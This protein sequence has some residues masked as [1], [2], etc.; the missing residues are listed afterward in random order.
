MRFLSL[1]LSGIT[2]LECFNDLPTL[3]PFTTFK[4]AVPKW[5]EGKKKGTRWTRR[6]CRGE[7]TP[8]EDGGVRARREAWTPR[9]PHGL[10]RNQPHHRLLWG[11]QPSECETMSFC[12]LSHPVCASLLRQPWETTS[13]IFIFNLVCVTGLIKILDHDPL[14]SLSWECSA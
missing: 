8:G 4:P 11:V 5:R 2:L 3:L 14:S 1:S 9:L 10:R 6:W 13:A 7:E 12:C